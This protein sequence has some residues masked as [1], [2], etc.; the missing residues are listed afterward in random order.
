M[1]ASSSITTQVQVQVF[2]SSVTSVLFK[3]AEVTEDRH[4]QG[5][6]DWSG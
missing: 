6:K 4:N 3:S 2:R 5:P 1:I